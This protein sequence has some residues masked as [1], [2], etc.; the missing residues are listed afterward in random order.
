[1][2]EAIQ[3][4]GGEENAKES[5]IEVHDSNVSGRRESQHAMPGTNV[6]DRR[7]DIASTMVIGDD[8]VAGY[9]LGQAEAEGIE[10]LDDIDVVNV[11]DAH[12]AYFDAIGAVGP[13]AA[14]SELLGE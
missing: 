5:A 4:A 6:V 8:T 13:R 9:L 12:L 10:I 3:A 2:T 1:M 11:V 7:Q 14:E